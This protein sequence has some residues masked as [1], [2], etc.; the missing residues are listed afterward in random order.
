MK[1]R[2]YTS[3]VDAEKSQ[4]MIE[5][6]LVQAGATGIA[7]MYEEKC[8][9]G[10]VF[11][12]PVNGRDVKFKMPVNTKKV[13]EKLLKDAGRPFMSQA[14]RNKIREQAER[15]AWKLLYEW[16][17]INVSMIQ[18]D[19][20]ETAQALLSYVYDEPSEQTFYERAKEA[21]KLIGKGG[22]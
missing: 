8:T 7:K 6:L 5:T 19:Q 22:E 21:G 4:Q 14:E 16:V 2:N 15:T 3:E 1:I 17:H 9:S 13:Y 12:I 18:L 20:V 11:I 10:F